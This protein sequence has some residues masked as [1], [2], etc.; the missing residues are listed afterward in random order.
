[1]TGVMKQMVAPYCIQRVRKPF[2]YITESGCLLT[3]RHSALCRRWMRGTVSPSGHPTGHRRRTFELRCTWAA[4]LPASSR[5]GGGAKA[6]CQQ[7]GWYRSTDPERLQHGAGRGQ[8]ARHVAAFI[9][10]LTCVE[11]AALQKP[12]SENEFLILQLFLLCFCMRMSE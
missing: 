1:M 9:C 8:N 4:A 7:Q 11:C 2:Q 10:F 6:T 5:W 3:C 12:F